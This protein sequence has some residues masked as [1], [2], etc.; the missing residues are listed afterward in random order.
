MSILCVWRVKTEKIVC[1]WD[2]VL[3]S[4]AWSL[5]TSF[6]R[7]SV[8]LFS[9]SPPPVCSP[10]QRHPVCSTL[11]IHTFFGRKCLNL[12]LSETV[13]WLRHVEGGERAPESCWP[14]KFQ[15][16]FTKKIFI[17]RPFSC[18]FIFKQQE[19]SLKSPRASS[20][21]ATVGRKAP[22]VKWILRKHLRFEWKRIVI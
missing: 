19:I 3:L 8:I 2:S 6:C 14:K 10:S 18:N 1:M 22:W 15:F 21:L 13:C 5:L 17:L 12:F 4:L 11:D 16:L 9:L 20:R 7:F